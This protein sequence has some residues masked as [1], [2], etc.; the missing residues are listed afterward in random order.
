MESRV[1]LNMV[2]S[3]SLDW[4]CSRA[5]VV[6]MELKWLKF[7]SSFESLLGLFTHV[8]RDRPLKQ[9]AISP[10]FLLPSTLLATL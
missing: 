5:F 1:N 10:P 9:A 3:L 6:R 7:I 4:L 8:L 2:V